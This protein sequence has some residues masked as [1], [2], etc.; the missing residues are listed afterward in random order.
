MYVDVQE[1]ACTGGLDTHSSEK[2]LWTAAAQ[3]GIVDVDRW[4]VAAVLCQVTDATETTCEWGVG[5][6]CPQARPCRAQ[7][8]VAAEGAMEDDTSSVVQA[9]H[10]NR[11]V[12]LAEAKSLWEEL[13]DEAFQSVLGRSIQGADRVAVSIAE[14]QPSSSEAVGSLL[15]PNEEAKQANRV[16]VA[17][18]TAAA[19][20]APVNHVDVFEQPHRQRYNALSLSPG[21][22]DHALMK[23]LVLAGRCR[24]G[25]QSAVVGPV[26]SETA[27]AESATAGSFQRVDDILLH[28]FVIAGFADGSR[29]NLSDIVDAVIVRRQR[30]ALGVP[31]VS[32]PGSNLMDG[33]NENEDNRGRSQGSR[34]PMEKLE[35][36]ARGRRFS[37]EEAGP[38]VPGDGQ[39]RT[40]YFVDEGGG[41]A[42]NQ[43]AA[44]SG[45]TATG[46]TSKY[47]VGIPAELRALFGAAGLAAEMRKRQQRQQEQ[48]QQEEV[49]KKTQCNGFRLRLPKIILRSILSTNVVNDAL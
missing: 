34:P 41:A 32:P 8:R 26:A 16:A 15:S 20:V 3:A 38:V 44:G 5:S 47:L 10:N 4:V 28:N 31:A 7:Q 43:N 9:A 39:L 12:V 45:S 11:D 48:Q 42:R 2:S 1:L 24:A 22:F 27:V 30:S 25:S 13:R 14:L 33:G 37:G 49:K 35:D 29:L 40:D 21:Y 18:E 17:G 6:R 23:T 36:D 19:V 46:T